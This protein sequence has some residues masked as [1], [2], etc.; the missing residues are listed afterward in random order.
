[1]L[2]RL[3]ELRKGSQRIA[4]L[5]ILRVIH[6]DQDSA[7][8]LDDQRI[9]RIVVHSIT[10]TSFLCRGAVAQRRKWQCSVLR[11][12]MQGEGVIEGGGQEVTGQQETSQTVICKVTIDN[13]HLNN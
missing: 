3:F 8:P 4:G 13:K 6:L 5:G 2:R 9:I 7:I 12:A 1:M 11:G 10:H